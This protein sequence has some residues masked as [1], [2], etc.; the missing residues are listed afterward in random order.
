MKNNFTILFL[1]VTFFL[2]GEKT[3]Y[4]NDLIF[5]TSEITLSN[6]GNN[7]I[8]TDGIVTSS[9]NKIKLNAKIFNYDKTTEIL[10]AR[11]GTALLVEKKIEIK[12]DK[13]LYNKNLST[14]EAIGNVRVK[15]LDKNI[16][17]NTQNIY[18]LDFDQTIK[19]NTESTIKD[20]FNNF[21]TTDDFIYTLSDNLLKIT[22]GKFI[23]IDKNII[24]IEKGYINLLSGKLIG[25][26]ISI[27]F[28]N[29]TFEKDNEP[30]LKGN[31]INSD[32]GVSI[33]KK[34]VFTTCK[35]NND[36]PPWQFFAEEIK[37]DK[38][39]KILFYKNAWLKIYDKPVLYFPKFFHPDPTVKRQ[40]GF[41]M[42]TLESSTNTGEALRT[43]YYHVISNNKDLTIR[44]RFYSN[45]KI[46]TQSEYRQVNASS[47]LTLDASILSQ[48]TLGTK[49]HFFLKSIKKLNI[50]KFDESEILLKLEQA[51]KDNYLKVYK[52]KSPLLDNVNTMSSFLEFNAYREDLS[53][54]SSFQVY[55]N[56]SKKNH[57]RYEYVYPNFNINKNFEA[58]QNMNGNFY[59]NTSGFVKN[60]N[61][62]I[63]EKTLVNDLSF[64]SN[65]KILTNGLKSSYNIVFKNA[66]T[67]SKNSP[68]Y[69]NKANHEIAGIAEFNTSYPLKKETDT[70]TN[71][72]KPL[73]SL[74]YSPNKSKN[75]RN[76]EKRID[77]NNIYGLNRIGSNSSVEGGLSLTY[78][79]EF[80]KLNKKNE[81]ILSASIAN[82]IKNEK[83]NNISRSSSLGDKTSNIVGGL[84]FNLNNN[85]KIDYKFAQDHNLKDTNFQ[86]IEGEFKVNNFVTSFEYLNENDT[87]EK[88]S[89]ITNKT[90]YIMSDSKNI[91]FETRK[92]K[93]TK[94]TEFYNLVYQY[95]NDCL[96]AGLEYNKEFYNDNSLKPEENIFFKLTIIPLGEVKSPNIKK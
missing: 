88:Q 9:N 8:A 19:S 20:S 24:D 13:F 75:L 2:L 15:H 34:G 30:R 36:C 65:A 78:G 83:D 85:I 47:E 31:T 70:Y 33:I 10:K 66:N 26:D 44:P 52:I 67:D 45:E 6:D 62:N 18:Y 60:Y 54:N 11:I 41:L 82:V 69:K 21:L 49:N 5:D 72:F 43:P 39:K 38:K 86:V 61:T 90:S 81:E 56:L 3:A 74:R 95:R 16:I 48:K 14:I 27:N 51:S 46:L 40:S 23:D 50:T 77:V 94:L 84:K 63:F 32:E 76:N 59:L 87:L 80:L 92:N 1:I 37:H 68:I 91:A 96:I 4:S 55:E 79:S 22:N 57:D 58:N 89:Y 64:N 29:K 93:K 35:K 17:I 7:I 42:P 71:I 28:N 12:A 25:K 53:I 73:V